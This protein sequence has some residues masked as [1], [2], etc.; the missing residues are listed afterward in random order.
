MLRLFMYR[1][2]KESIVGERNP[3]LRHWYS[4]K[5]V[6]LNPRGKGFMGICRGKKYSSKFSSAQTTIKNFNKSFFVFRSIWI[7]HNLIPVK[8][9]VTRLREFA[10]EIFFFPSHHRLMKVEYWFSCNDK[11]KQHTNDERRV[12]KCLKLWL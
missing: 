3:I 10:H 2:S 6:I 11:L 4:R 12:I 8:L 7:F 9:F 1:K 5:L